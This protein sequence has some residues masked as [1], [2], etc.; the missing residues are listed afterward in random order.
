MEKSNLQVRAERAAAEFSR[1]ARKPIVLEFSGMPKA[2]KTTV[3]THLHAFLRRCGFRT[4]VVV[5]RASVCPIRDKKHAHFNI[6]T[7]CTTLSQLLEK[8]QDPPSTSDP[9]ILILDRGIFDAILWMTMLEDLARIRPEQ[10]KIVERFLSIDDWRK[11]I[12]AVFMMTVSPEKAMERE[13]GLLPV[14]DVTG[15]IMN[16]DV[17]KK[18]R[19]TFQQTKKRLSQQFVVHNIDTSSGD[20]KDAPRK[21]CED[22]A[23]L[24][25]SHIE[26]EIQEDILVQPKEFVRDSFQGRQFLPREDARTLINEFASSS[27]F[28]PRQEVEPDDELVQA[29]PVVVVRNSSGHVLRLRR[30]EYVRD[31]PLHEEIVVWAGGHVRQEDADSGNP[32]IHAALRELKEELR[33]DI[34]RNE[35]SLKGAVYVDASGSTLRHVALC[36]EWWAP[37]DDVAVALC[38]HEFFERKG[39][40]V[41]G[42]FVP[43]EKLTQ[44][45]DAGKLKEPW[46]AE[47]LEKVLGVGSQRHL[48]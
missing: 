12:T 20:D 32:V 29:L 41:S 33:L 14:A 36:F 43:V 46:T 47:I 35:L 48:F 11:R 10:R 34:D 28:R 3:I 1:T 45:V 18:I 42:S 6:W 8:T 37:S 23:E 13:G 24:V 25:L 27:D 15:S 38:R 44:D 31:N 39:T 26:R 9:H 7:A 2:G 21:T 19:T 30:R 4:E 17:L 40:S 22:V 16:P 5:E